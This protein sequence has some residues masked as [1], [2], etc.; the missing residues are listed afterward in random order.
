MTTQMLPKQADVVIIGGGAIGL[1]SAYYLQ[2]AGRQVVILEKGTL[3]SGCSGG[4]AGL[5]CPSHIEPLATPAVLAQGMAW[6]FR[7]KSPFRIKPRLDLSLMRWLLAFHGNCRDKKVKQS[8][9]VLH[10]LLGLSRELFSELCQKEGIGQLED[11]G[12]LMVHKSAKGEKGHQALANHAASVNLEAHMLNQTQLLER[13]PA[14]PAGSTGA[15]FFPTD[16]H[17]DPTSFLTQISGHIQ[18]HGA[19]ILEHIQV[20]EIKPNGLVRTVRGDIQAEQVLI[21]AGSWSPQLASPLGQRT[22]IQP[23]KG[24]TLTIPLPSPAP[25]T[26]MIL[27]EEKVSITPM[28]DQ[29][30]FGGTLELAGFDASI[31]MPRTHNI[32][33]VAKGYAPELGERPISPEQFWHGYRPCT[34]DGLPVMGFLDQHKRIAIASGHAMLGISLAPVSGKLMTELLTG[35]APSIPMDKLAPQRF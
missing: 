3:L 29:L 13:E 8:M 10:Q 22:P 20:N 30:R 9:P 23:G 33:T 12:L 17:L 31:C 24:Y 25:K 19:T 4:N 5:I 35:K 16:A 2:Q 14:V 7:K 27:A 32:V 18:E 11:R 26:P 21:A 1:V 15:V 6:L 28:G 34:P